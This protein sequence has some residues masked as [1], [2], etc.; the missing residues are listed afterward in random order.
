MNA[1]ITGASRGLGRALALEW[2]RRGGR[3]AGVARDAKALDAMQSEAG[4]SF[5][6]IVADVGD[7][8]AAPRVLA[9]ATHALGDIQ[10]LVHNASTLGPLPLRPL[11]EVSADGLAE[12]FRVNLIGPH[13]LTRRVVG[14]MV[15]RGSGTVVTI[16]SDVAQASYPDW[17][18]YAAS[19]AAHDHLFRTLA[20]EVPGVRFVSFD[21]GEMNTTMHAAAL[22]DADPTSLRRPA[23]VA[24]V[25]LNQLDEV[26]SGERYVLEVA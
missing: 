15:V 25:L 26:V 24:R 8:Q 2:I 4:P 20:A 16:S 12:V 21:P 1:L 22:P 13:A 18:A 7:A 5:V 23:D 9:A 14:S 3:V 6:P 19:K 17:G 10:L 11:V